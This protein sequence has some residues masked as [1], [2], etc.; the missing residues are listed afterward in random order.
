M[1]L[2]ERNDPKSSFDAHKEV[3][4]SKQFNFMAAQVQVSSHLNPD[5]WDNYFHGY[6]DQQLKFLICYGFPLDFD[7][8]KLLR[9]EDKNLQ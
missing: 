1:L 7:Y 9:H 2:P 4:E 8:A 6:W 3:V 5:V